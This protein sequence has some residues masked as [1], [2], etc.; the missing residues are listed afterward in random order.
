M[1]KKY[2]HVE[3]FG[4]EEVIGIENGT[5]FV[6]PKIDGTNASVWFEDGN[7]KAGS[8]N[9]ELTLE[10]DNA[11]FYKWV[12]EQDYFEKFFKECPNYTLYGEWLVPHTLKTYT[13]DAWKNFYV[14][15][16]CEIVDEEIR[17]IPY[18]EY[19]RLLS[20]YGI[21]FIPPLAE[22]KNGNYEKFVSFLEKNTFLIEDGKGNGEG[23]VIKNYSFKNKYGRTTWAKIVSN[24]FKTKHIKEMGSPVTEIAMIEDSIIDKFCTEALVLKVYEKIKTENGWSSKNIPQLLNTVYYDLI[25]EEM[26]EIL[27]HFK[28][29]TINFTTL[30]YKTVQKVKELLPQLF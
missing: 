17:Y 19:H 20:D 10:S 15:D 12:L 1:F 23:I 7:I 22:I 9:K 5:C 27:K 30:K 29:P 21:A 3:R 11:G 13:K 24:D 4:N 6:F 16:V 2:Q 26:W 28:N 8:R 18:Y 25:R 14:F